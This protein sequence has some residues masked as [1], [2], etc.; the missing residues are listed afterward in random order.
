M[1]FDNFV[2]FEKPVEK[3]EV[4]LKYDKNN[5]YCSW[6]LDIFIASCTIL[7]K[8]RTFSDKDCK[9][10]QNTHFAFYLFSF[11]NRTVC[12]IICKNILEPDR[13]QMTICLVE[14]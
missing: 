13:P 2:Y 10:N 3:I 7:L 8:M 9:D 14:T 1:K 6:R 5:G 12:E 11:E 4:S